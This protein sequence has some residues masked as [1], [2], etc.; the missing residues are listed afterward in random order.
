MSR[1]IFDQ[2]ARIGAELRVKPGYRCRISDTVTFENRL[3]AH[4]LQPMATTGCDGKNSLGGAISSRFF[5]AVSHC[6]NVSK[7]DLAPSLTERVSQFECSAVF[8]CC[9]E[10]VFPL[11]LTAKR[12][13]EEKLAMA[14]VAQEM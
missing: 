9:D 11:I 3:Q 14:R 7:C 12:S 2:Y 1:S 4:Q 8:E 5:H 10:L 13:L 6:V